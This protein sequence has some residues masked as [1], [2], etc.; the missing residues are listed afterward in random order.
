MSRIDHDLEPGWCNQSRRHSGNPVVLGPI[1]HL[2][3]GGSLS[4]V[5]EQAV[6][7]V[8]AIGALPAAMAIYSP[9]YTAVPTSWRTWPLTDGP[10]VS[11]GDNSSYN[12][13]MEFILS[14]PLYLVGIYYWRASLTDALPNTAV[15]Q[16]VTLPHTTIFGSQVTFTDPGT[17]GWI[18]VIAGGQ[19]A[20]ATP[21]KLIVQGG[22]VSSWYSATSN[23]W[24]TGQGATGL[25]NGP[26]VVY[27]NTVGDFGQDTFA[28]GA[29]LTYPTSAFNA[30]NYWI[31]VEVGF[32]GGISFA[33][34]TISGT[35]AMNA[36]PD[37]VPGRT[38]ISGTGSAPLSIPSFAKFPDQT[39]TGYVN[40]PGYTG[41]LSD[42]SALTITSNTTYSFYN[43]PTDLVVGANVV[44]VT[45][46]GCSFHGSGGQGTEA[47]YMLSG[48]NDGMKFSYCTFGPIGVV[49]PGP[50]G[51]VA[52]SQCF[53]WGIN[54][55]VTGALT[56]EFCDCWGFGNG[57]CNADR[58]SQAK[59][60]IFQF[61]YLHDQC[62]D[63]VVLHS[64]GIGTPGGGTTSYV[65]INNNNIQN[66]G[67]SNALGYQPSN[68]SGSPAIYDHFVVTNNI[69][70]GYGFTIA[71]L[72]GVEQNI[73]GPV[74][75]ATNI[76]FT[77]NT[78]STFTPIYYGPTYD[79]SFIFQPNWI[80]RNNKWS[81][82]A[83]AFWGHTAY[84]GYYWLPGYTSHARDQPG[85]DELS[86]GLVG[87][88]DYTG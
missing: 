41:S 74:A 83:N 7:S 15:I 21:Y 57:L 16:T 66:I 6:S 58:S 81:V 31:D 34:A 65:V 50:P 78:F 86:H 5:T 36:T 54:A 20:A 40:A 88:T 29:V 80:W 47:V 3:S 53:Q 87:T 23:Y 44:N 13:G 14:E 52:L 43:F 76:I 24:S 9:K 45:F 79:I 48:G 85:L 35:S 17:T 64:D 72:G 49:E 32:V 51:G 69:F 62:E 71:I 37:P 46:Y 30:T 8:S 61:N 33:G 70:G 22:G 60:H 38:T 55:L 26:L 11:A 42:G 75:A 73:G 12:L 63:N 1:T 68:V 18:K 59:P 82:P 39:T 19:L 10:A 84:D 56:V 2:A 28:N 25:V 67:N 4:F 27:N 77:G